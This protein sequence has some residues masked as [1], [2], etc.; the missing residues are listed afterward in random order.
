[1]PSWM[2]IRPREGVE[3]SDQEV[4]GSAH[5]LPEDIHLEDVGGY[6]QTEHREGE[7]AQEGVVALESLFTPSCSP[8]SRDGRRMIWWGSL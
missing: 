1:M 6:N 4:R 7:E 5:K 2:L 8:E 3:E